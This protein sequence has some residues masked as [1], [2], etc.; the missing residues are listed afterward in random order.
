MDF[1]P[2]GVNVEALVGD[3]VAERRIPRA[4]YRFQFNADFTFKDAQNLVDYLYMLGIS[5]YYASP[6]FKPRDGSSH[7][8]DVVDYSQLNP[9]LGG[10]EAFDE[11]V[12]ALKARD[13]GLLLDIVPNHMGIGPDNGWWMDVLA[14]GPASPYADFFDISWQ[15]SRREQDYKVLLPVLGDHY[16]VVLENGQLKLEYENNDFSLCYYNF[17]L[18]VT[19]NSWHDVLS[20]VYQEALQQAD[21]TDPDV[22]ELIGILVAL[23]H[24]PR[25]AESDPQLL[26]ERHHL[27][28]LLRRRFAVLFNQSNVIRESLAAAITAFNGIPE[29]PRSFDRLDTLIDRQP[30]RLAFW[31]V[32]SDEINYRR[33]F[34]INDMAAVRI[35][36]PRVFQATHQFLIDLLQQ[37]KVTGLRI[38]HPDGLWNPQLYFRDL[39]E[40]YVAACAA[41]NAPT[42]ELRNAIIGTF[43][44]RF[45]RP[46]EMRNLWPLYVVVEKILSEVEPLPPDWAVYGTTGYDFMNAVNGIFVDSA[47]TEKFDHLYSAFIGRTLDFHELVHSSKKM[48]MEHSLASEMHARSLQLSRIVERNRRLRGFTRNSLLFALTE[49]IACMSIYRTY[50]VGPGMVSERDREYVKAA[51]Q[52]ARLRNPRT[53]ISIFNFIEDVLLLENITDFSEEERSSVIEFVMKFQ[54]I[55]GPV[56]AKGVED[57]TFY[58]FNRLVS[59][60][61]VGGH[62][63]QFGIT[64][65]DFHQHNLAHLQHWRHTMLSS[66]THDTKRSE[67]VRARLNVLSEIPDEWAA[68]V[69]QWHGMNADAK[70]K[71]DGHFAPDKNDEYLLYQA[72]IGAWDD[73][74]RS[75]ERF[76]QFKQRI[77]AYMQKAINEAKVHTSWVNPNETYD[78]AVKAFVERI[79]DNQRFIEATA[80]LRQKIAFYGQFN[81]LSQ[82]LLKLTAP[83]FPDIYQGSELWDFSLVD[84]DNRRPVD[85]QLRR[86]SLEQI[87]NADRFALTQ[88]LLQNSHDG[89]IKLFIIFAVLNYRRDHANLFDEGNYVPFEARGEKSAHVCAFSRTSGNQTL[90]VA[91][92]RLLVGLTN[93]EMQP[94]VGDV[95]GDTVLFVPEGQYRNVL[96]GKE[97]SVGGELALRD[98]FARFPVAM[99]EALIE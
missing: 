17:R 81:S 34:D 88:E 79:L 1:I 46:E 68:A 86:S 32:A 26:S 78:K 23:R 70:T 91:V 64:V 41:K 24:L 38:D 82:T 21:D 8:Y 99:L 49:V 56:M 50:N 85:Y 60:N 54:Q 15:H 77:A 35:E 90:I 89:R 9:A 72:I 22:E 61:E 6:I 57:T 39:Q 55:T 66:S 63:E 33:F 76:A 31:R 29:N 96:T 92:P 80:D 37:G 95:W 51:V 69:Q 25:Y 43:A 74:Q 71:V 83:G 67:D 13:M 16:G 10:M 4:T 48:I 75:Q 53:P 59:L 84:P 93:G 27:Q 40:E 14:N 97:I 36:F 18:P 5:E 2:T 58:I 98:V 44:M 19:I 73:D 7:G 45:N 11:L 94:P 28:N 62:P 20:E 3:I 12:N 30:Y 87:K 47:N 65:N 42:E 52:E